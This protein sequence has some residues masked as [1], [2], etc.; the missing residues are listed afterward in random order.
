MARI[1]QGIVGQCQVC[2]EPTPEVRLDAVL[3]TRVCPE[4]K[5]KGK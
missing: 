5:E 2:G 3:W 4:C 1:D